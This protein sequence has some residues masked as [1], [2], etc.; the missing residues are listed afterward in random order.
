MCARYEHEYIGRLSNFKV[1]ITHTHTCSDVFLVFTDQQSHVLA[2]PHGYHEAEFTGENAL[3]YRVVIAMITRGP[4]V[5]GICKNRVCVPRE[6]RIQTALWPARSI[7]IGQALTSE[8]RVLNV[9]EITRWRFR[10]SLSSIMPCDRHGYAMHASLVS[11]SHGFSRRVGEM[12]GSRMGV[13]M[14]L[15]GYKYVVYTV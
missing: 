4:E 13:R 7:R 12:T 2:V 15:L 11:K 14:Q 5:L 1:T 9:E 3:H 8:E 6:C 10:R